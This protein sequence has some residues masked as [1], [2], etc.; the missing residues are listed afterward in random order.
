MGELS[1]KGKKRLRKWCLE[2]IPIDM[3]ETRTAILPT[4]E[5]I[6]FLYKIKVEE[7]MLLSIGEMIEF[8]AYEKGGVHLGGYGQAWSFNKGK[9][10]L[11][12]IDALWEATKEKLDG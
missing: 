2:N 1:G 5:E 10:Y 12:P 8:L 11:E 3:S 9:T 7:A 6:S 4:K